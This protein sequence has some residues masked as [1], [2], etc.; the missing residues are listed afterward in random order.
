MTAVTTSQTSAQSRL[1][2][3]RIEVAGASM[4][5][6]SVEEATF[7]FGHGVHDEVDLKVLVAEKDVDR[8]MGL[9]ISFQ[10]GVGNGDTWHGYIRRPQKTQDFQRQP[11]VNLALV[12]TTWP[13]AAGK[14]KFWTNRTTEQIIREICTKHRLGL[15]MDP[16]EYVWPRVA[17][18]TESDWGLIKKLAGQLGFMVFVYKGVVRVV[19]PRETLRTTGPIARLEKSTNATSKNQLLLDFEARGTD[20]LDRTIA[21]PA[22]GYHLSNGTPKIVNSDGYK[23]DAS[24]FL[25]NEPRARVMEETI[26]R[27]PGTWNFAASARIRGS[28]RIPPGSVVSVYTGLSNAARDTGDGNWLVIKSTVHMSKTVYQN[29]LELARD[30]TRYPMINVTDTQ[31]WGRRSRPTVALATNQWI[32][33]WR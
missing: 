22:Y 26:D 32:S 14:P 5:T 13:M 21:R 29:D 3:T 2:I 31:F 6:W 15:V 30:S 8:W 17:Q 11:L 25:E 12:G 24:T 4:R 28:H 33:N 9:P 20:G 18:T 1:P 23:F 16:H 27:W 19:N 10:W 7:R